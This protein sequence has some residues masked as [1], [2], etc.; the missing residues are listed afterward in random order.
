MKL[1]CSTMWPRMST[2]CISK[3][4]QTTKRMLKASPLGPKQTKQQLCACTEFSS[5]RAELHSED[6]GQVLCLNE[7]EAA[8]IVNESWEPFTLRLERRY[9]QRLTQKIQIYTRRATLLVKALICF[10]RAKSQRDP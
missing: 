1:T 5:L 9:E 6:V 10:L 8:A 3:T 4:S 7:E 2:R